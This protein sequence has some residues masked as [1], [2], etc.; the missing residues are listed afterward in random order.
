VD[1]ARFRFVNKIS[2]TGSDPPPPKTATDRQTNARDRMINRGHAEDRVSNTSIW[3]ALACRIHSYFDGSV[4]VA[5][6]GAR[7]APVRDR[8]SLRMPRDL[9]EKIAVPPLEQQITCRWLSHW[10]AAKNE[11]SGT[12][13]QTLFSFF[14]FQPDQPTA[15]RLSKLLLRDHQFRHHPLQCGASRLHPVESSV[16]TSRHTSG[17]CFLQPSPRVSTEA[18]SVRVRRRGS[19]TV[20]LSFRELITNRPQEFD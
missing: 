15:F 11:R 12:E 7:D 5:V 17:I 2:P 14:S 13:S 1:S 16:G 10:Q 18:F 3:T 9:Q 8:R 4:K 19:M 6:S 20:W